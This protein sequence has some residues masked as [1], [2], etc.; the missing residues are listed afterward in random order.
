MAECL[1]F[2]EARDPSMNLSAHLCTCL[3]LVI[4][5]IAV[6]WVVVVNGWAAWKVIGH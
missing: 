2:A 4:S 3:T 1:S 6:A 5:T